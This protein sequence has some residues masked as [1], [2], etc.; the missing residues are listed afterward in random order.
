MYYYACIQN[1]KDGTSPMSITAKETSDDAREQLNYDMYYALN[2]KENYHSILCLVINELGNVERL[3]RW[4]EPA[5][6]PEPT[7]EPEPE[8][9]SEE[10]E[11]IEEG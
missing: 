2:Q 4:E 8:E 1:L 11:T 9:P 3:D 10:E 5:P 7:P 6:A